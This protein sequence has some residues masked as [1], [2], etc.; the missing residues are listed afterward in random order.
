MYIS[1]LY[2]FPPDHA[3]TPWGRHLHRDVFEK[4]VKGRSRKYKQRQLRLPSG[5]A[6]VAIGWLGNSVPTKG[7]VPEDVIDRL[8]SAYSDKKQRIYDGSKGAHACECCPQQT[9]EIYLTLHK[10]VEI[11]L[12][13]HGH[14]LLRHGDTVYMFPVLILH[15][16]MDHEY[17]P[18]AEFLDAVLSGT[19]MSERDL[20]LVP[21]KPKIG[22]KGR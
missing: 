19:F 20:V 6:M 7:V 5:L 21:I 16:I 18:P 13:G 22:G 9:K 17:Q 4:R 2:A 14:H 11:R 10:G 3:L 1:D 12:Y 8:F 15:Y